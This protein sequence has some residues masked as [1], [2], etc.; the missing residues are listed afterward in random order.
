MSLENILKKIEQD[1]IKRRF[2]LR[3]AA[4]FFFFCIALF[5]CYLES[6]VFAP[7]PYFSYYVALHHVLWY[8]IIILFI[9][10]TTHLILK[11]AVE[12]LLWLMYGAVIIMIPIIVVMIQGKPMEADYLT[13]SFHEIV[14]HIVTFYFTYE[15]NLPL[16]AEV[17]IIFIGMSIIG[18]LYTR[19]I[20]RGLTLG[21]AIYLGGN[22]L[23]ISW[24][25]SL[26]YT[27]AVFTVQ[28]GLL[29]HPF[30]AVL[31][32]H[33]VTFFAY[34]IIIRA[35]LIKGELRYQFLAMVIAI[36]AGGLYMLSVKQ[37]GWF[38]NRFDI[39]LTAL[40]IWTTTFFA[41]LYIY[42]QRILLSRW[43][44]VIAT[45]VLLFQWAVLGPIY[46]HIGVIKPL[47]NQEFW[48]L[49]LNTI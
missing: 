4:P 15:R 21:T 9:I 23:A 32:I 35:D 17:I 14:L 26:P 16:T 31:C 27:K 10:L 7:Q 3:L 47:T 46:F 8:F 39:V 1:L 41:V 42:R 49:P 5:R 11:V 29:N 33:A 6:N 24:L 13:G 45:T 28:S 48:L 43:F 25:G 2:A 37:S 38:T 22:L 12:K 34:L 44:W 18:Y 19:S 40:P 20:M 30:M 36:L